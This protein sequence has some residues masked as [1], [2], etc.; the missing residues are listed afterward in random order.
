[1]F[2]G[3][4]MAAIGTARLLMRAMM[5]EGASESDALCR[6]IMFDKNGLVTDTMKGLTTEQVR[7]K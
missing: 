5:K 3:A 7:D 6:I 1:M 2:V 4:G